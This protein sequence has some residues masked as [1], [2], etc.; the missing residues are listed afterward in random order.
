MTTVELLSAWTAMF[1]FSH[2][3]QHNVVVSQV[4]VL[5]FPVRRR[6]LCCPL[7]VMYST[8]Q[9]EQATVVVGGPDRRFE[10]SLV[11]QNIPPFP[12]CYPV[13]KITGA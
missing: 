2:G 8:G 13:G 7:H 12:L 4:T 3:H 5:T 1:R 10:D 11:V 9:S 6:V